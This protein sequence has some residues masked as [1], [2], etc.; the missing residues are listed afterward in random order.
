MLNKDIMGTFL[1]LNSKSIPMF[2]RDV[3]IEDSSDRLNYKDTYTFYLE[4][5]NRNRH[6]IVVDIPKFIED[7]FLY[8]GGNKKIILHQNFFL[9]IVNITI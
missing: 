1:E 4:D 7:R 2:L 9:P 5:G 3:K 6:T 8:I